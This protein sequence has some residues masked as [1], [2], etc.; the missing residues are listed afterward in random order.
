MSFKAIDLQV[1]VQRTNDVGRIQ[2]LQLQQGQNQDHH[3][4]VQLRQDFN[5]QENSVN[6]LDYMINDN[7]RDGK[8]ENKANDFK[9]KK[10]KLDENNKD[11]QKEND[12]FPKYLGS[13]LD[14]HI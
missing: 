6:K 8:K 10:K 1:M 13:I 2:Q 9:K 11:E 14:L 5:V 3:T 4:S 7:I 12:L